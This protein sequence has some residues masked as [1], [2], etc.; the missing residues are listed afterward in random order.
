V[1][2]HSQHLQFS[3][4][5]KLLA[6][7]DANGVTIGG[8]EPNRV[9]THIKLSPSSTGLYRWGLEWLTKEGG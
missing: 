8:S 3:S 9:A 6:C 1:L 2:I 4:D 5:G 7:A